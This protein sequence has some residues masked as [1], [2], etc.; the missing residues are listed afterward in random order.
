MNT[1]LINGFHFPEDTGD[2]WPK[3][4]KLDALEAVLNIFTA[5]P[6][7]KRM[8]AVQAGGSMGLWPRR[9][10]EIFGVVYTFE[11]EP[12]S[13]NCLKLNCESEPRIRMFQAALGAQPGQTTIKRRSLTSHRIQGEDGETPVLTLDGLL[14]PACDAL[15]LDI[16][17]SELGALQGGWRTL[18]RFSPV[19]LIEEKD[20]TEAGNFLKSMGYTLFQRVRGDS[21]FVKE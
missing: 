5:L 2:R 3:S 14:L 13:F 17:G 6:Q 16:E 21:I 9:L 10:A 12:V 18:K 15:F 7:R 20:P 19:V 11:P 8:I 1:I 4:F